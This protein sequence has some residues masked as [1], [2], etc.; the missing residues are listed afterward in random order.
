V[1]GA[2][3]AEFRFEA[4]A[5]GEIGRLEELRLVAVELRIEADLAV[6]QHH[7][8]VAELEPLVREHPTREGLLRLYLL[9]LYRTG[10]QADALAAYETFRAALSEDLGL[11]PGESLQDLQTAILRHDA[12]LA[13]SPASIAGSQKWLGLGSKWQPRVTKPPSRL[14][15]Q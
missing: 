3:A 10:R 9:A 7:A 4:F 2:A 11:D 15:P 14:T 5:R 12:T 13:A 1:A 6:G 8:V